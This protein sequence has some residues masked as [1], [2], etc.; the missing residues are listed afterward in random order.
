MAQPAELFKGEKKKKMKAAYLD[1]E[2]RW[3]NMIICP[4]TGGDWVN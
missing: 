1:A 4:I 2:V 3:I